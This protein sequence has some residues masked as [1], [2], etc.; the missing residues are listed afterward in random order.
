MNGGTESSTKVS[1]ARSDVT[2]M[3]ITGEI[4]N[5]FNNFASSAESI[6]DFLDASTVLHGDD[7]ELI[8]LV[9]PNEEGLGGVM[10]D[11]ST[12]RPVSV[13]VASSE[14]SITLSI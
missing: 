8:F 13:E 9:D 2:E 3:I 6:E 4:A 7:S 14:E 1:W 5:A 12:R 11:T 10:E